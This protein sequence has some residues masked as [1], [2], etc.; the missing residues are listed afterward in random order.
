MPIRASLSAWRGNGWPV[1]ELVLALDLPD[2]QSALG[3]LDRVAN[4]RWVKLGSVLFTRTGP[5]F[6]GVLKARGYRVFL[7][8]KWHDIPNTVDGAVRQARELGVDM[9]TVH[10]LGG[11]RMIEA[12]KAAGGGLVAV[13][14][15]TLLTSHGPNDLRSIYGQDPADLGAEVVRLAGMAVGAGADG[16]V[17]SP[18]E[19]ARLRAGLGPTALLVTPGIR[20]PTDPGGDQIR[21]ATAEAAASA[22][23]THL[24]VGRPVLQAHDPAAAWAEL[25]RQL[26]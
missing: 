24:V 4:V 12:A 19:V 25:L 17:S 13:I 26:G 9:V 8:L 16:V 11:P 2:A 6:V 23:S 14:A 15:V 7:D 21:T 22:G 20:G 10:A 5:D 18:L 3:L 1:A